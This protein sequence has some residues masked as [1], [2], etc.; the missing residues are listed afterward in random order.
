[1]RASLNQRRKYFLKH[2][3]CPLQHLVIPEANHS[4]SAASKILRSFDVVQQ[5][6]RVLTA[7][8]F[9]DKSRAKTYEI[10]DVTA[11]RLL[12]PEPMISK[13]PVSKLTPQATFG[14]GGIKARSARVFGQ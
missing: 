10:D 4:K 7:V 12:S 5:I 6:V 11:D 13:M 3:I 2:I 8:H 14:I 9:D 1:V